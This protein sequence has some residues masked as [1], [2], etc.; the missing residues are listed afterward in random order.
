[1]HNPIIKQSRLSLTDWT[2]ELPAVQRWTGLVPPG[3]LEV[4][5]VVEEDQTSQSVREMSAS[6]VVNGGTSLIQVGGDTRTE[7]FPTS[8]LSDL[9]LSSS[10]NQARFDP[11][12]SVTE[13][14]SGLVL[15]PLYLE[16][17]DRGYLALLSQLTSV[18]DI[19]REQ[20]EDR[21]H[22]MRDSNS[23][24]YVIVVE[25]RSLARLVGAAT[26]VLE[27]KFIHSCGS[28][29]RLEDVV[30]SSDYRGRQ[31][32]KLLV[33]TASTL[34]V[35]LGSYKVTIGDHQ[36]RQLTVRCNNHLC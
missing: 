28:V 4:V 11:P 32:G 22:Q 1:M 8:L 23:T 18:G 5:V 10:V 12:L 29:G 2:L 14:G 17:Y 30:V 26:L 27:R 31:L 20:W 34:A 25:D 7:M 19:S 15:R 3:S 9:D 35:K 21:W 16:D 24:Y 33:T 6:V 36:I 13:P